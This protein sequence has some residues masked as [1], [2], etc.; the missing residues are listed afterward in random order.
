[1]SGSMEGS[2]EADAHEALALLEKSLA[3]L[4]QLGVSAE[5]GGCVDQR[6]AGC[7]SVLDCPPRALRI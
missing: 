7:A 5:I 4:D 6:Y 2:S 1:M 3:I